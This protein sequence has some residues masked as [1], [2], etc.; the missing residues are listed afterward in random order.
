MKKNNE[1]MFVPI[2]YLYKAIGVSIAFVL[3]TFMLYSKKENIIS[4]DF[5]PTASAEF[6]NDVENDKLEKKES[7]INSWYRNDGKPDFFKIVIIETKRREAM[8]RPGKELERYKDGKEWAIGYGCH[9]KYLNDYWKNIVKKQNYKITEKQAREMMYHTFEE[10]HHVIKKDFPNAS[11]AEMWAIKSLAFNWG[12]G[13]LKKSGLYKLLKRNEKGSRLEKEWLKCHSATHNHRISR[14]M[15]FSL[16]NGNYDN[17][18][19]I[20]KN[21]YKSLEIRG[22]F[23]KY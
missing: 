4:K 7:T 23:K 21:A 15:E 18:L 17:C 16:W 1:T 10:L 20:G 6:V 2:T 14:A 8:G 22:D 3:I 12:Y 5:Y 11:E 9:I 13:N 19:T